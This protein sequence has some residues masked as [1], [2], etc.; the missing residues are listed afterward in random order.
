MLGPKPWPLTI[1]PPSQPKSNIGRIFP[2]DCEMRSAYPTGIKRSAGTKRAGVDPEFLDAFLKQ[3]WSLLTEGRDDEAMEIAK[4]AVRLQE[5]ADTRRLFVQS[6]K[7]WSYFP[8]AEEMQDILVRALYQQWGTQRDLLNISRGLL[9][10]DQV[11]GP[12]IRRASHFWPDRPSLPDLL[13]G[14]GLNAFTGNS[15]LI[16]LLETGKIVGIELERFL[17][18][19]RVGLLDLAIQDRRGKSSQGTIRFCCALARQCFIN[20]YVF[21]LKTDEN[22]R[23]HF[24]HDLI[25]EA[26]VTRGDIPALAL[27]VLAAYRP[28]DSLSGK[29][30]LLKRSW[31]SAVVELLDQQVREPAAERKL[32]QSIP[33]IT[34]IADGTSLNVQAQY[35]DHPYP[36]WVG[37]PPAAPAA[38]IDESFRRNFPFSRYRSTGKSSELDIL[39]AGCGTGH[40]SILFAQSH[41]R[42]RIL[43]V[44]LS[45][46]SLCYAKQKTRAMKITNIEYAQADILEL[47]QLGRSFD[48]ISSGGVLHHLADPEQ[49]WRILLSLLRSNGC[50]HVG[51]YSELARRHI[52]AAQNWLVERGY[53]SSPQDIRRARPDLQGNARDLHL[54]DVLRLPDFYSISECRDLLFPTQESR[55]T[56][57]RIKAFLDANGLEFLGFN[58]DDRVRDQFSRRFSR[59]QEPDLQ[60]WDQFEVDN[61]DTFAGMYQFWVQRLCV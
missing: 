36:R 28:L 34:P 16:A 29:D 30:S 13:G 8:G 9:D 60:L 35:E 19:V 59:Q 50:M 52:V 26:I 18:C 22:E 57:S 44:D 58:I 20:E 51:L 4:R 25:N 1:W 2:M 49:G 17:T 5:T 3:G 32:R 37:L 12:A 40:H 10:R 39:I 27:A 33:Q 21:E 31:P 15:L 7:H 45:L 23:T 38:S 54:N 47:G 41:P 55:F 42:A 24:L 6:V 43:A 46:S 11:I 53:S 48:V 14:G 61:P 56:I